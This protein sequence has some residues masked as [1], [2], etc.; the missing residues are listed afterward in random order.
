MARRNRSELTDILHDI[1]LFAHLTKAQLRAVAK[2]ATE[3]VYEPEAVIL[4]QL[5]AAQHMVAIV[6]GKA[7]VTRDGQ[8]LATVGAGD[9]VG[10][11]SLIDGQR[12]SA[13]VIAE[14]EV[15]GVVLY[16]S[17]FMKLLETTPA[18]AIKL[19][20]A[21]TARL[22]EADRKLGALG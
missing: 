3:E 7:R 11:M 8:T 1:P 22:R 13:G 16:R 9:V 20:L 21:Q 19:L 5:D 4:R 18:M 10:E 12:R 14:T 15:E 2:V 6:H 17:A